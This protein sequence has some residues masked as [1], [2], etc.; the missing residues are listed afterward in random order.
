MS[1]RTKWAGLGVSSLLLGLACAPAWAT[2]TDVDH[3]AKASAVS[4][5][6]AALAELIW[7]PEDA[8]YC[9]ALPETRQ[10]M[11]DVKFATVGRVHF[12]QIDWE[13]AGLGTLQIGGDD[14]PFIQSDNTL[15]GFGV[16]FDV[17]WRC[18]CLDDG[19][20]INDGYGFINFSGNWLS[21]DADGEKPAGNG[22]NFALTYFENSPGGSTGVNFGDTAATAEFDID[23]Y[24]MG[25]T[26]GVG[27][28]VQI[29]DNTDVDLRLGV[30]TQHSDTMYDGWASSITFPNN[31]IAYEYDLDELNIGLTL[32][33]EFTYYIDDSPFNLFAGIR[34][35][36]YYADAELDADMHVNV[37]VNPTVADRVFSQSVDDDEDYWGASLDLRV[38][39]E[40]RRDN[41]SAQLYVGYSYRSDVATLDSKDSPLDSGPGIDRDDMDGFIIGT[42][43][44]LNF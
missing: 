17:R 42:G 18:P 35:G 40:Y 24:S 15:N 43:F 39:V 20:T 10:V 44:T 36:V 2:E 8:R 23:R 16:D 21:G 37:P 14:V 9:V 26:L 25:L 34:G 41:F 3:N 32:G 11:L 31:M 4:P 27:H 12:Q 22:D 33:A 1:D 38:G 29:S 6:A 13:E 19:E 28:V 5:R 30:F 7:G